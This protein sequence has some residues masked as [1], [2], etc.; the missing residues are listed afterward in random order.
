MLSRHCASSRPRGSKGICRFTL[1]H[2]RVY[3]DIM[4][5]SPSYH[6]ACDLGAESGRVMLGIF[7]GSRLALEEVHRFPNGP[8]R[9]LGSMRWDLLGL[10][11]EILQGLRL[12]TARNVPIASLGIDSW[13]IDFALLRAGEPLL[14]PAYH[15]R[16]P[17]N[18]AAFR[19]ARNE[20][21]ER[22]VFPE[23]GIQFMPI[24]TLYQLLADQ[25]A[26]PEMLRFAE[27]LLMVA[28]WCHYLLCGRAMAEATNASTTQ[29]F[30]PRTQSWSEK[31]IAHFQFPRG[32]FP[33]IVPPG[34]VLGPLLPEVM[35]GTG[36]GP[37]P[38]IAGCTHDTAA[39]VAAVPAQGGD[40]AYLSSGTW[41]LI[42]VELLEPLIND[43]VR[44]ANF[45]NEV[46]YGGSIR[47]L[48]NVIGMWLVQECRR[49]WA[50]DGRD[51]NYAALSRMADEAV[52]L[53]SLIQANDPR[54]HC[55][56]DM[57]AEIRAYCRE[58]GQPEPQTPTEIVR[59][60]FD[61]LALLYAANLDEIERLT[62][63]RIWVLHIVGGGSRNE[64]LNQLTADASGRIVLAGPV[65]A[66]AL[67][68]VLSQMLALGALPTLQAARTLVRDSFTLTR[69]EPRPDHQWHEARA[70]FARLPG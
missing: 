57:P 42:G 1:S 56:A 11:R 58:T 29:L 62:G 50:R 44:T 14:R 49:I 24:N 2:R 61:S 65:E 33:E 34:T 32:L 27:R 28:D 67:G 70:R 51:H 5:A 19:A 15:Y 22:L 64:L 52:P 16:D 39:A 3:P 63:R 18:E 68:N 38:V 35:Q 23:T 30:D 25:A 37:V 20:D 48:K 59:C 8:I 6:V 4:S 46:G 17:R 69:Y 45:T 10:H 9:V 55:P 40:W 54:F 66:T 60:I 41:S 36:L 47:F 12:V 21:F 53:R 43:E 13:A 7:D 26:E 31:L